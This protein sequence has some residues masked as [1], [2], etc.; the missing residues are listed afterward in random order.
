MA[1]PL[2]TRKPRKTL[3]RPPRQAELPRLLP[4]LPLAVPTYCICG[5]L[6]VAVALAFAP[7]LRMPFL[8]FDDDIYVWAEPHVHKG[9]SMESWAWA[10]MHSHAA[11]WH[12]LTTLSHMLDCQIFGLRPWGHHLVNLILHWLTTALVFLV[13]RQMTGRL[14]PS[15]AL[16]AIFA[17][18]PLRVESVVWVAERKDLLCG[19]CFWLTLAAYVRYARQPF[20]ALRYGLVAFC[21][22]L[23]LLA[24]PM[25]VTLPLVMLVLD[26]W[27]LRR[28]EVGPFCR[29][30]PMGTSLLNKRDLSAESGRSVLL[31]KMDLLLE[32]LPLLV[33][34]ALLCVKTLLVQR[35]TV[36]LN[37]S[38]PLSAR[39]V[40][41]L[42][43]CQAYILQTF[44]PA[45]LAG[46]YPFPSKMPPL[47]AIF[48]AAGLLLAITV[49]AVVL[50]RSRPY[51]LAGWLWFLG[52]LV[53]VLGFVQVGRQAM[54]DRYTYLPQ[55][56]LLLMIVF[57]IGDLTS[58]GW[59]VLSFKRRAWQGRAMRT[60]VMALL[61]A[62]LIVAS[63]RQTAFWRDDFTFMR[64]ALACNEAD[65][66]MHNNMA[67]AFIEAKNF[68]AAL[69]HAQRAVELD[70]NSATGHLNLA[71]IFIAPAQG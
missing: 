14:W 38:I 16:A 28:G 12:P 61:L 21:F 50:R 30:G 45:G 49:L 25:A 41:A 8:H 32:K 42:M 63:W 62:A 37:A 57:G 68:P 19:L 58:F 39:A 5:L 4:G 24:K 64:R 22:A 10:W 54:A 48:A 65:S 52:M 27:P 59:H 18:H 7:A 67:A 1:V 40:N 2:M 9:F 31:G 43:S 29:N 51:L 53:P 26:Y 15:A 13:V 36:Q 60:F 3:Q 66:D 11:N 6:A 17:V 33:M 70:P 46:H 23:A 56:G 69:A 71:N 55:I 44:W 34:S 35:E 20:S 47:A